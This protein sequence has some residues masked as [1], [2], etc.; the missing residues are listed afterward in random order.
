MTVTAIVDLSDT[1]LDIQDVVEELCD[2]DDV[3]D[4]VILEFYEQ[5]LKY[6]LLLRLNDCVNLDRLENLIHDLDVDV[7]WV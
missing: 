2:D 6:R 7:E 3:Q 5:D 1:L 4:V